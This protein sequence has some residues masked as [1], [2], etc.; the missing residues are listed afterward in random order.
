MRFLEY[1]LRIAADADPIKRGFQAKLMYIFL[2]IV[3]PVIL[4]IL[5]GSL[6]KIIEKMLRIRKKK[7]E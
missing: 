3:V 6:M 2:N 7:G 5:L 1:L 4:G